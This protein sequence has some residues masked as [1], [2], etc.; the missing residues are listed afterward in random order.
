M[1]AFFLVVF[2]TSRC[3]PVQ[4]REGVQSKTQAFHSEQTLSCCLHNVSLL[5]APS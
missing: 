2:S 1:L 5:V 4:V 3:L